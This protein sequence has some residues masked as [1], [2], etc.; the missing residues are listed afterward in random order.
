MKCAVRGMSKISPTE[1]PREAVDLGVNPALTI[2]AQAERAMSLWPNKGEADLRPAQGEPYRSTVAWVREP[3]QEGAGRRLQQPRVRA[4]R[5]AQRDPWG[6]YNVYPRKIEELL[7]EHPAVREVAVIGIPH[8]EAERAGLRRGRAEGRC[9]PR[10]ASTSTSRRGR[11]CTSTRGTCGSSPS[12]RS[13]R[14]ARSSSVRSRCPPAWS[15]DTAPAPPAPGHHR[16]PL[17][18]AAGGGRIPEPLRGVLA[19]TFAFTILGDLPP[20]QRRQ[21]HR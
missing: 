9:Y 12:C 15:P 8:P 19:A 13:R 10:R 7:Y 16:L 20:T 6:G 18:A 5:R 3:G 21:G 11:R 14:P 2:T 4:Q 1:L 17:G